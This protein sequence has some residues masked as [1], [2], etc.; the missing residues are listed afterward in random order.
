MIVLTQSPVTQC[1]ESV[2]TLQAS[3]EKYCPLT[4]QMA[5]ESEKSLVVSTKNALVG[6]QRK[7]YGHLWSTMGQR[8]GSSSSAQ[9][10]GVQST[11]ERPSIAGHTRFEAS[12]TKSL[13]TLKEYGPRMAFLE[14]QDSAGSKFGENVG[15]KPRL[16]VR[17]TVGTNRSLNTG[18][19]QKPSTHKLILTH[20]AYMAKE[21]TI[22]QRF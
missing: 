18:A 21:A 14:F 22:S 13:L 9:S 20:M 8:W 5:T 2:E 3:S 15:Q 17:A 4:H 10:R 19:L 16:S 7:R 1:P 6:Q 11:G 12:C